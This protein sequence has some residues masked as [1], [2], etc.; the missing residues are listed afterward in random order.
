[1][2][3]G[4]DEEW[5]YGAIDRALGGEADAV[6]YPRFVER[7]R[8]L[9]AQNLRLVLALD[10]F[11][12]IAANVRLGPALFNHL[13]AL[14]AQFPLQFVTASRDPLLHLTF[15]H[16]ETMSSP[17]FNIFAPQPLPLFS[18]AEAADLL[19]TLS[20]R[21]SR[22]FAPDLVSALIEYV[23][24]HPLFVQV[25]GYRAFAAGGE[26]APARP[27]IRADLDGH[28]QYYWNNL[29]PDEQY[30]LAALPLL[31]D[32]QTPARERLRQAGLLRA[33]A[34]L[35]AA[36]EEFI[37]AQT[38]AGLLQGGPFL[39]DTRRNLAAAHGRSLRLT[40]TELAA[41]KLFL[42]R[43]SETFTAEAIEAALWPTE[44][45]PDPERARGVIKKLRAALGE[46]GEVI[47]N[48]R[49]QGWALEVRG[50]M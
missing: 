48:R 33:G 10:E 47:V 41:L 14:A 31:K 6:P 21:A 18:E 37:R 22:P 32:N 11:E 49:G 42:E 13:R 24:P 23:G 19:T 26:L 5:L 44:V 12:L 46:T 45:S 16:P 8:A 28:L 15:A 3:D 20:T 17:F 38:V 4:L 25:A 36:L 2:F 27:H 50:E 35:G 34:Y 9:Q 7:L 30:A 39:L 29:S 40:P 43:P 1:M